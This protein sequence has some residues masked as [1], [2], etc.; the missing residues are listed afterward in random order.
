[1]NRLCRRLLPPLS[2]VLSSCGVLQPSFAAFSSSSSSS[3]SS[4]ASM[5]AGAIK[6]TTAPLSVYDFEVHS[7]YILLSCIHIHSDVVV[8]GN[9]IALS[10]TLRPITWMPHRPSSKSAMSQ[11]AKVNQCSLSPPTRLTRLANL[12]LQFCWLSTSLA[13]EASLER[14]TES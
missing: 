3:S 13:P 10:F 14:T 9:S 11:L 2:V 5:G 6:G 8:L 1:M 4:F 12:F 7:P